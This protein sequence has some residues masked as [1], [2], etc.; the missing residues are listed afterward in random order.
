MSRLRACFGGQKKLL[1]PYVTCGDPS[2]AVTV[3]IVV[4]AAAAGADAIELGVP[5]SDPSADGPAIQ[6]G[7]ERACR[8]GMTLAKTF[9]V[10][11]DV[12][13]RGCEIPLILFGYYNP[14]YVYGEKFAKDAVAAGADG[15]L[16]VDLPIDELHEL[17]VP[18]SAAG[19]DVVPLLAPT[20][21]DERVARVAKLDAPFVYYVSMT[22][23]TGAALGDLAGVARRVAKLRTQLQA[24]IAVGFGIATAADVRAAG[25]FA[26]A[27]VVGSAIVRQIENSAGREAA[28]VGDFVAALKAGLR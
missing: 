23:I 28:V 1:I 11:R 5:F 12:R 18:A 22:G 20:S 3:D 10:I 19:L 13:A 8:G 2:A 27:V 15:V 24:P 16:V 6:R 4:A 25:E 26:D 14:I 9:D 21:T 7:M 17:G